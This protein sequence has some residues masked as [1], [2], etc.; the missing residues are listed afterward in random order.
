ME[1]REG[2]S[3]KRDREKVALKGI[4]TNRHLYT[5]D[6]N[7]NRLTG[8]VGTSTYTY[9]DQDRL[10]TQSS[11]LS[12][13][14]FTYTA[15]GELASKTDTSTNT[16]TTYDYDA[17][18][19]LRS[20]TLPDGTQIEYVIDGQN[21]R[22]SKKVNN[23]LAQGFLYDGQL[24]VVAELDGS[25]AVVSRFIYGSKVNVPDYMIK[26]RV[27]YRILSDHLGS[28]RLVINVTDGA[29]VQRIDYDEFGNILPSSTNLG[30]QPFG[31][32]GGLYD[33]DTKLT[34]FGARDYDA[35][36]GRWTAKDPIRFGGNDTNLYG[37]VLS[38]PINLID[39][40]GLLDSGG[41]YTRSV[42]RLRFLDH[43]NVCQSNGNC[44]GYFNDD[45]VRPDI[46]P[47]APGPLLSPLTDAEA[48]CLQSMMNLLCEGSGYDVFTNNCQDC[49]KDAAKACGISNLPPTQLQELKKFFPIPGM[50][51]LPPF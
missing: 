10:L 34:R 45:L 12:T 36:T 38:D 11:V 16:S 47:D 49:V 29:I 2:Y 31:F 18:G 27:T 26:D 24:R 1:R 42:Q 8:P 19:N 14:D 43:W 17:F 9:D 39:F 46:N 37:Y 40:S 33:L 50:P 28:P 25:G 23:A 5:Y 44:Q 51:F 35:E 22:V 30:F 7:G 13:Q 6:A 32:A 20:V 41:L 21:R 3:E 48:S 15:N 4:Y